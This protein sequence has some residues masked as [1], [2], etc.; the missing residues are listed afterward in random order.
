MR[1]FARF[2]SNA[3]ACILRIPAPKCLRRDAWLGRGCGTPLMNLVSSSLLIVSSKTHLPLYLL[4][5][6]ASIPYAHDHCFRLPVLHFIALLS[7]RYYKY[8]LKHRSYACIWT[9]VGNWHIGCKVDI[10]PA[11]APVPVSHTLVRGIPS[12]IS[13]STRRFS[14]VQDRRTRNGRPRRRFSCSDHDRLGLHF[15]FT[16][17]ISFRDPLF[18]F[19]LS[20]ILPFLAR[21]SLARCVTI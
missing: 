12:S 8:I 5:F 16:S 13:L 14:L 19:P 3:L 7:L 4:P 17:L 9:M 2:R 18:I 11:F 1:Q 20:A 15:S 6:L 21:I 10:L